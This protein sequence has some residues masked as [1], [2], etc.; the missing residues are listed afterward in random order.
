METL[1]GGKEESER[2]DESRRKY[3]TE[4]AD[5]EWGQFGE[6]DSYEGEGGCEH[7]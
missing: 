3:E 4:G 2:D 6:S 1:L 5:R 7:G